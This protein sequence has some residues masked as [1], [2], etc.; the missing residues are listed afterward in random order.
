MLKQALLCSK[1][2]STDCPQ[3]GRE[4]GK[5]GAR[6]SSRP[7]RGDGRHKHRMLEANCLL[8]AKVCLRF[9]KTTLN[10]NCPDT[11]SL[12]TILVSNVLYKMNLVLLEDAHV[13]LPSS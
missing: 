3:S 10:D 8:R 4:G 11:M 12:K 1:T 5:R 2:L 6:H 13:T 9:L 7:F